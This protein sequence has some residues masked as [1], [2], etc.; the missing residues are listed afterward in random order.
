MKAFNGHQKKV[1]VIYIDPPYNAGR[2][3][4]FG[5]K[6]KWKEKGHWL[7]F[8][9]VRLVEA[10]KA[11]DDKGI[12][13][14]SIADGSYAQLKILMD[15]VFGLP[16]YK[17]TII[18]NKFIASRSLLRVTTLHEYILVYSKGSIR[19]VSLR[20]PKKNL[21]QVLDYAK[22]LFNKKVEHSEAEEMFKGYLDQLLALKKI[23]TETSRHRFLHPLTYR[24]FKKNPLAEC[25]LNVNAKRKTTKITHP[26]MGKHCNLP[27]YG[28]SW[29]RET[30]EKRLKGQLFV[31]KNYVI[32][33]QLVFR[34]ETLGPPQ[35]VKFLDNM[36]FS[37]PFS[38]IDLKSDGHGDLPK[39]VAFPTPKPVKL[40]KELLSYYPN[41]KARIL[42]FFAGSGT[43]G[44]AVD[45]LNKE[46]GGQR[47]CTL[48]EELPKTFNKVLVPRLKALKTSDKFVVRD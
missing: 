44:H 23:D 2:R 12:I 35:C 4:E 45:E 47:H 21:F 28:W 9:R 39:G 26:L 18:W 46:D 34:K 40:I 6:N 16:S 37:T 42:D 41:K 38:I 15:E 48:V 27:R 14:V 19:N 3:A 31:A 22:E 11:L 24:P 17:G 8:M 1:D 13:Y 5:Y 30:F 25:G 32:Q 10:H 43:T 36:P 29:T 20:R 33:G 7:D